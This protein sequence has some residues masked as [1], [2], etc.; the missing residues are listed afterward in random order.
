MLLVFLVS[1]RGRTMRALVVAPLPP[2]PD[3]ITAGSGSYPVS[4]ALTA[5]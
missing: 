5:A 1:V 4:L 3:Q 2:L